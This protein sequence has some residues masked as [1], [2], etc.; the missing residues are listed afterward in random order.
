MAWLREYPEYQELIGGLA[1]DADDI[2]TKLIT[3]LV[4]GEG[5]IGPLEMAPYE[6]A[7]STIDK[8]F[9]D[10]IVPTFLQRLADNEDFAADELNTLDGLRQH[11]TYSMH[12]QKIKAGDPTGETTKITPFFTRF[13]TY[14]PAVKRYSQDE[15]QA[16]RYIDVVQKHI[17]NQVFRDNPLTDGERYGNEQEIFI[18]NNEIF[19]S[20]ESRMEDLRDKYFAGG[21]TLEETASKSFRENADAYLEDLETLLKTVAV[22]TRR[23]D[24]HL[25]GSPFFRQLTANTPEG[26]A[27]LAAAQKKW[28]GADEEELRYRI[29]RTKKGFP[30]GQQEGAN[31]R[32]PGGEAMPTD[33][34]LA[35][36]R[37]VTE[38]MAPKDVF[39][40]INR[41]K[42][43]ASGT[44]EEGGIS[45][46]QAD[47]I[48]ARQFG[49]EELKHVLSLFND[50]LI[51]RDQAAE[52]L[53]ASANDIT[54]QLMGPVQGGPPPDD[55]SIPSTAELDPALAWPVVPGDEWGGQEGGFLREPEMDISYE[56]SGDKDVQVVTVPQGDYVAA[57][58]ATAHSPLQKPPW[59]PNNRQKTT[60]THTVSDVRKNPELDVSQP[61]QRVSINPER[62]AQPMP[63]LPEGTTR[64]SIAEDKARQKEIMRISRDLGQAGQG[65][66]NV[67]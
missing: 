39:K 18:Q 34:R 9:Y 64:E 21:A 33:P 8:D 42:N 56:E 1:K 49:G 12:A 44:D 55:V 25:K 30:V 58:Q 38:E 51:T 3:D 22:E 62:A 61:P 6:E 16:E 13:P 5:N 53:A 46:E 35:G 67:S 65:T 36:L 43:L 15:Q 63:S 24:E 60:T 11:F 47:D 50:N 59:K 29:E 27:E 28:L 17:F 26:R 19:R 14:N 7:A 40:E 52:L 31:I 57:R 2:R 45:E 23:S 4:L 32:L 48:L 37:P 20:V 41:V 10:K 66:E 54:S